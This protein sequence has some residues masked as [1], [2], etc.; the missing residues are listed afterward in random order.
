MITREKAYELRAIIE[1]ASSGL[2]DTDALS[3]PE[4]FANWKI[5]TEYFVTDRVRYD[6]V[7]YKCLQAHTS[8]E[9]WTPEAA[10]SLWARVLIPDPEVIPVWEQPDSTNPYMTGDKVH[11]PDADGPVYESLIDNNVWSPEAYPAGWQIVVEETE[12][13]GGESGTETATEVSGSGSEGG[14]VNETES[15]EEVAEWVQPTATNP[16]MT[17]DR[18]LYNGTVYESVID[19]NVWDPVSYPAG[20]QAVE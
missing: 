2:D 16:Y 4:L 10:A 5:G 8:Q 18:V 12:S 11:Y 17:G 19:N 1:K 14:E 9:N 20:W 3:A 15:S 13:D 6:G 7:L